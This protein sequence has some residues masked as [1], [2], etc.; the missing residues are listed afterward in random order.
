MKNRNQELN[1]NW[2]TPPYF[3]AE[4]TA[5]YGELFDPFPLN[6]NFEETGWDAYSLPWH[7]FNF[8]NPPYNL[9]DKTRAI[10][11]VIE[12]Q[13]KGNRSLCL[14]PV[15]T[16]TVLFQDLILPN[17]RELEFVKGRIPFIGVNSKGQCVNWNLKQELTEEDKAEK[18]Q[19]HSGR[20]WNGIPKHVNNNGQHDSMLVLF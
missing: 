16:S 7:S 9:K 8:V 2:Q 1:D 10:K 17:H 18:V 13:K 11:K 4:Q 3:L 19:D 15:S 20:L 5:K 12:E 6:N 14:L